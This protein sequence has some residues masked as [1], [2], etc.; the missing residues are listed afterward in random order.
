MLKL[1]YTETHSIY[2]GKCAE[3]ELHPLPHTRHTAGSVDHGGGV[4]AEE[5]L[6][7]ASKSSW[8]GKEPRGLCFTPHCCACTCEKAKSYKDAKEL[9]S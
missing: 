7:G 2:R 3:R 5:G 4:G 6:G 8:P 9:Y 1:K